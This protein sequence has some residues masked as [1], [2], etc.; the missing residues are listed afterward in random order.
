MA[1]PES[2]ADEAFAKMRVSLSRYARANDRR[3]V[4]RSLREVKYLACVLLDPVEPGETPIVDMEDE[5]SAERSISLNGIPFQGSHHFLST[6]R[7]LCAKLCESVQDLDHHDLYEALLTRMA[8]TTFSA[9]AYFKLNAVMGS[10]DLMLLPV[11][12]KT[13]LPIRMNLYVSAGEIHASMSSTNAYGL[14]RKAD[15][16]PG[17][18]LGNKGGGSGGGGRPWISLQGVVEERVNISTGAGVRNVRVKLPE[19]LY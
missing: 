19:S 5:V 9:D 11:T 12:A 14:F 13:S 6:V 10:S 4:L 1:T 15:V 16:K 3:M 7:E 17:D 18:I 2:K 8:R